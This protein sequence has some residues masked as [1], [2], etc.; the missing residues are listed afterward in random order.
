MQA[1][2]LKGNSFTSISKKLEKNS[3]IYNAKVRI[4][5][6]TQECTGHAEKT[7]SFMSDT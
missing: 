6:P 2:I 1:A 3:D 7:K 5:W 4:A